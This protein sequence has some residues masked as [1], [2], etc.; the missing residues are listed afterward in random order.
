[1]IRPSLISLRMFCPEERR[2]KNSQKLKLLRLF[3]SMNEPISKNGEIL[4]CL[5]KSVAEITCMVD[6]LS[7][8]TQEIIR[9]SNKKSHTVTLAR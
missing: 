6:I 5:D 1:M 7:I 8:S 2:E 4:F 9:G 3:N